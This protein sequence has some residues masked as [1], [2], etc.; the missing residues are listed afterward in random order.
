MHILIKV[1]YFVS[2]VDENYV[3]DPPKV[4]VTVENLN[5]NVD[6]QFLHNLVIK[7][8]TYEELC[9]HFHPITRLLS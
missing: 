9:I 2:Q 1:E 3:G 5:D 6:N 4:E 7:F 8:G